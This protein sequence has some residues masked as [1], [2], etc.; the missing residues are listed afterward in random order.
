MAK[1]WLAAIFFLLTALAV[2]NA[3]A[4]YYDPGFSDYR[5]SVGAENVD[6]V[7]PFLG[8]LKVRQLDLSIPGNGGLDI[9]VWRFYDT[10]NVGGPVFPA[11]FGFGAGWSANF[12]QLT[13]ACFAGVPANGRPIFDLGDGTVI[14]FYLAPDWSSF[15]SKEGWRGTCVNQGANGMIL[16]SPKGIQYQMTVPSGG[17]W[18]PQKIT[19]PNG[20][21]I[22]FTYG[23]KSLGYNP[24]Q[25][26]TQITTNDGR[27]V[28]F[29]YTSGDQ[30]GQRKLKVMSSN[31]HSWNYS[32]VAFDGL[33]ETNSQSY[34]LS[35]VTRPDGLSWQY[36][37]LTIP[38]YNVFL[39]L[40]GYLGKIT[41]PNK[42]T[43]S[44]DYGYLYWDG[45][46]TAVR[47]TSRS[48]WDPTPGL[49]TASSQ[50]WTYNYAFELT[51]LLTNV[52]DPLGNVTTYRHGMPYSAA[53]QIGLM[54]DKLECN[55]ASGQT[56][57]LPENAINREQD[58]WTTQS[59]S[60]DIF[61][62]T[63]QSGFY[64]DPA[65]Y[66]PL[67][68][69]KTIT[70]DGTTY[71]TQYQSHDAYGNPAKIIETGNGVTRTTDLTYYNDPVKWI[72]GQPDKETVDSTWVTDRSFD[73][74]GNVLSIQKNGVNTTFTYYPTG[75]IASV[76]DANTNRTDYSDYYRGV[77]RRE[78][79]PGGVTKYRTVNA[80]GTVAS[81]TNGE[82]YRTDYSYDGLNRLSGVTPPT[83]NPTTIQWVSGYNGTEKRVTRG[84]YQEITGHDG[85]G[86]VI[87]VAR[88]DAA[89]SAL[90]RRAYRYDALGQKVFEIYPTAST[91]NILSATTLSSIQYAYDP[92]GRLTKI[93][94]ADG[95]TR[96]LQYLAN[97][98][99]KVTNENSKATTYGYRSFGDPE[100]RQLMSVTAP[101]A[102]ANL[103]LTRNSLGQVTSM[104]QSGLTR[105]L[106]YDTRGYLVTVNHPEIG[107]VTY[108]RDAVGNPLSKTV[109][110]SPS[111]RAIT[112][113]Y[114]ARNRLAGIAYTDASTP[115]VTLGYNRVDDIVSAVRG[116]VGRGYG[117]DANRNLTSEA[118]TLDGRTFELAYLYDGNDAVSQVTYPDGQIVNYYPDALGRPAA[119]SPYVTS[120][121]Y[122]PSGQVSGM[123]Y[124]NGVTASQAFN[125]RQWPSQVS[126]VKS[127]TA[128]LNTGYGYDGLGNP[129]SI[130]DSADAGLNRT[131][132]YDDIDRL[133]SV[134]G[135][136]GA[137][138]LTYDG[139][140]NLLTQ[141]YGTT[142]SR[143]YSYDA[144]NRLA[145]Y[146]GS[147]AFAYDAWGNAIRSGTALSNHTF[148]DASNLT[149]A[150]CDTASPLHFEYDAN[151]YR[152]KKTRNGIVTYSLYAKDGNLMMEYTPSA[153]DLKQFA[154][155]NK[156]Q[157]AMRHV[158][159][160]ALNLGQNGMPGAT[161]FA[162]AIPYKSPIPE[163]DLLARLLSPTPLL[164]AVHLASAN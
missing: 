154:Y 57:C 53:W 146:T 12:G 45:G 32:Y 30:Y 98:Q 62:L 44:Y 134:T 87:D 103:T 35:Q 110:I 31:G 119:V 42:G 157:V 66:R 37:Y 26:V 89:T 16:T 125:T 164:T 76:T 123:T 61:A 124:A 145:S 81:E 96:Q 39:P 156:K 38:G 69:K 48:L 47:I 10:N 84:S 162:T 126:V 97:N 152:V 19:D 143:T 85:F 158:V 163:T 161:R 129:T 27:V 13:N 117:Y 82:G 127:G 109:G 43:I 118:L 139:R 138:S 40:N 133:V 52:I 6:Y 90:V 144:S 93:T 58:I 102:A 104:V 74:N 94:H 60:Y 23:V 34:S 136:W 17:E 159:D 29:Q 75:D 9:N 71:V 33:S 78:D 79:Q 21:W 122:H 3:F 101:L 111:T 148:D 80:T 18:L 1:D 46:L 7:D 73:A 68:S 112:Y 41:E 120:V 99:I 95:K 65:T 121:V 149:C 128:L 141:N 108:G 72:V 131:L 106:Q 107:V 153:G 150:S 54:L 135:P 113:T 5:D 64:Q 77:P 147:T 137:G 55:P 51:D 20:N 14:K 160:P 4:L 15:I 86:R 28:T 140:G 8:Q 88:K 115:T 91:A 56:T 92:L 67:L 2:T 130:T 114:D 151:N 100:Q 25:Y 105:T 59:L 11:G 24:F 83:G 116:T 132:G 70:R 142:Y 36:S 155:H 49:P 63:L 50:I 22:N